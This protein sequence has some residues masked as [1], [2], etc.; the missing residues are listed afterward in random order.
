MG[1][2][3]LKQEPIQSGRRGSAPLPPPPPPGKSLVPI[4][5]IRKSGTEEAILKGGPLRPL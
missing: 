2:F 5:F 4:V 1:S 3:L